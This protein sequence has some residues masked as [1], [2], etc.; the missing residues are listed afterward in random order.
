MR[1]KFGLE[2]LFMIKCID[3]TQ[4]LQTILDTRNKIELLNLYNFLFFYQGVFTMR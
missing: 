1:S 3:R 2:F 4:N